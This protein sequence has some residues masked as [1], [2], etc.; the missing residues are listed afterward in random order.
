MTQSTS[1]SDPAVVA[2]AVSYTQATELPPELAALTAPENVSLK[3]YDL[4]SIDGRV[5]KAAHFV[6][7]EPREDVPLLISVHGSGGNITG[8]PCGLIN[9]AIP[10]M[11]FPVLTIN[12]RQS[13]S[14]VN[15]D[16]LHDTVR[17]IEAAFWMAKSLG[18]ERIAIHG[19][20]LGT[21]QTSLFAATHWDPAIVGIVLTGM[22]ADLAWKTRH[23]LVADEEQYQALHS[24]ALEAAQQSDF[25]RTLETKM[26]YFGDVMSPV[27][28][29]HFLSYR[30]VSSASSRSVDWI[31]RVPYPILM[32]RDE[33]DRVVHD[34]E[35]AWMQTSADEG[36]SPSVTR[37]TVESDPS[38]YG[39]SFATSGEKLI[40]IL[41]DWLPS[42][43]RN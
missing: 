42:L 9:S 24:Q 12:T 21:L 36:L 27:T 13:G 39:H 41:T 28:A 31:R 16:N 34:F 25:G 43:R 38:G 15:T 35:A 19:Q 30:D 37:F 1:Q 14:A 18:Y 20:S 5:G 11:G 6:P 22:F 2:A 29:N 40:E 32:V 33:N 7:D 4:R 17:D 3:F 23:M 8:G 26:P 10:A